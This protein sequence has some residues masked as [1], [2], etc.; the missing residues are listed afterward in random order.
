MYGDL[1]AIKNDR[2]VF[3]LLATQHCFERAEIRTIMEPVMRDC[4]VLNSDLDRLFKSLPE[5]T[6]LALSCFASHGMIFSGRQVILV[7]EFDSAKGFY[8]I[9]GVEENIRLLAQKY[10]NAYL[11]VIYACCRE[12]FM[13]AHHSGGIS[14]AQVNE[15]KLAKRVRKKQAIEKLE[16][17]LHYQ[18]K[19]ILNNSKQ[20][21][22]NQSRLQRAIEASKKDRIRRKNM[23]KL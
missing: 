12:I 7:N 8:K 21:L 19:A 14:L 10:P 15:I 13:V 3:E 22:D 5:E 1:N 4:L 11:V 18:L 2:D 20:V 16:K 17:M 9:F 6:V 23:E